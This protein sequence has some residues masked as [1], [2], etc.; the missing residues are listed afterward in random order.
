M[1]PIVGSPKIVCQWLQILEI[2]EIASSAFPSTH[3][4]GEYIFEIIFIWIPLH[5]T[6]LSVRSCIITIQSRQSLCIH[7]NSST[8]NSA[9]DHPIISSKVNVVLSNKWVAIYNHIIFTCFR[10]SGTWSS[11][12]PNQRD[13]SSRCIKVSL[14]H[15]SSVS[16]CSQQRW[17]NFL[18]S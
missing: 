5:C 8:F 4:L 12:S 14:V 10:M 9:R 15:L 3:T 16:S 7:Q 6:M 17:H 18:V 13:S 1:C 11:F 2:K